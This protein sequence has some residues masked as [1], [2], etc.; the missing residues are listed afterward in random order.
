MEQSSRRSKRYPQL[1]RFERF[2]TLGFLSLAAASHRRSCIHEYTRC[3]GLTAGI[4]PSFFIELLLEVRKSCT[5]KVPPHFSCTRVE[6]Y[7]SPPDAQKHSHCTFMLGKLCFVGQR[8]RS[9]TCTRGSP[10]SLWMKSIPY[11]LYRLSTSVCPLN[12][13]RI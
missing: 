6:K 7:I 5:D 1:R 13:S 10:F 8:P 12:F 3:G 2:W 4:P 11:K 9:W